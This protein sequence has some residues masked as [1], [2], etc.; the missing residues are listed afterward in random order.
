MP[1]FSFQEAILDARDAFI[2]AFLAK[3]PSYTGASRD[4]LDSMIVTE[5]DIDILFTVPHFLY[6]EHHNANAIG[7]HLNQPGP[8]N[9]LPAATAAAEEVLEREFQRQLRLS[10]GGLARG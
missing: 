7:F 9:V 4:Q 8:Y 6:N 3:V 1:T 2:E 10:L 5:T